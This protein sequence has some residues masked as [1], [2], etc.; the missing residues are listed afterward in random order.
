M[1][2]IKE[3]NREILNKI[4]QHDKVSLFVHERPDFD[5]LGSAYAM[6][7]FIKYN[8]PNKQVHI[9]GTNLLHPD[10][11]AIFF[12]FDIDPTPDSYIADSLGIILDTANAARIMTGKHKLCRQL[13]R[14]DHHPKTEA[15]CNFEWV[16]D[17]YPATAEMVA[18]IFLEND[19]T[20]TPM[21]AKYIYAGILTDT[22]R[23]LTTNVLPSTMRLVAILY[24]SGF[25]RKEVHDAIYVRSIKEAYLD[26]YVL[27]N[28]EVTK[29]GV[30]YAMIPKGL[31][32]KFDICVPH[33][34]VHLLSNIE[35]V[36]IWTTA[37]Y[38]GISKEWKGSVRSNKYPINKIIEMFNGGGH[39]LSAGFTL[40]HPKEFKKIVQTLDKYLEE[41]KKL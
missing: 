3:M 22:D 36:D 40:Q 31:N 8:W 20:I 41:C 34:K 2:E 17:R 5:A 32:E 12:K 9:I 15:I 6:Q 19:Y 27:K 4:K 10:Q 28:T 26:G 23:F 39:R 37:Y 38:D 25:D 21:V 33:V 1:T 29:N 11:G 14:I 7:E 13:M 24:E 18:T 16:D 30:A 35:N